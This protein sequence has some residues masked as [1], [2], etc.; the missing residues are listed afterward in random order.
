MTDI[1]LHHF[2]A[3]PFA[4]KVR[5]ALGI[6][7]LAWH[8]VEIPM[9][10]PKPDLVALTGGYRK[11]PVMQIGADVYCDTARIAVELQRRFGG[12]ALFDESSEAQCQVIA[13]WSDAALFR[14]GAGLS[15]GTNPDLPEAILSDRF[16][17]FDFLDRDSLPSEIPALFAQYRAG[18]QRLEDM[19]Q[20]GRRFLLGDRVSWADAACYAP[21]WMGRGNI[22][23]AAELF[24]GLPLLCAWE[25]R[26]A[27][28]GHGDRAAMDPARAHQIARDTVSQTT[29]EL[30][31]DG[32]P[33]LELHADVAVTPEDY[34]AVP[35]RGRLLRLTH[36]DIAIGREHEQ[37]GPVVVHFPRIGY[38]ITEQ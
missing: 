8:S 3:S 38:R 10:M 17:F 4:E 1:I 14:P 34:G 25:R 19:L 18:L 7:G 26:V 33:R 28:F 15:M 2:D 35:V 32:W 21:V 23:G 11:T 13:A 5:V 27:Q 31:Q 29:P 6:K 36:S 20:D 22:Q 16:A 9:V 37:T 24:Q 12:A 30:A